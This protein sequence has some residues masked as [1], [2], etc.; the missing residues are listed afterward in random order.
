MPG[1]LWHDWREKHIFNIF[2]STIY[3]FYKTS[4]FALLCREPFVSRPRVYPTCRRD[5]VSALSPGKEESFCLFSEPNLPV[6]AQTEYSSIMIQGAVKTV[7]ESNLAE[8]ISSDPRF[9]SQTAGAGGAY[10]RQ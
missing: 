9:V 8:F 3:D 7:N 5:T 1:G 10:R 2:V 6:S 4:F